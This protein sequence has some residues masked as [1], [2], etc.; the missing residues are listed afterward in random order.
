MGSRCEP[1]SQQFGANRARQVD[2]TAWKS[3]VTPTETRV[4]A[5]KAVE[6][7]T[8]AARSLGSGMAM[9]GKFST[10]QSDPT[11]QYGTSCGRLLTAGGLCELVGGEPNAAV[12]SEL[13]NLNESL[14]F[15]GG[16]VCDSI[17]ASCCHSALWLLHDYLDESHEISQSVDTPTGSYW[18]GIMHRREPDF[19]NAAY[20]F[21]RVGTH[22]VFAELVIAA[23]DLARAAQ[24]DE[25]ADQAF[26]LRQATWDPFRFID[27]CSA[28]VEG[29]SNCDLLCRQVAEAEWR[30]LFDYCYREACSKH[31]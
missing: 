8:F 5:P 25:H 7:G 21:R 22:P 23:R 13:S 18:H 9:N 10:T 30:L 12:Y 4:P 31:S 2:A 28:A 27:L 29:R 17:M 14:L 26:L 15:D 11:T 16:L 1:G 24:A 19:S 20:W 3:A 6:A